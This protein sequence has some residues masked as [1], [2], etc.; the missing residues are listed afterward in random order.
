MK[1]LGK[2]SVLM[3]EPRLVTDMAERL[4]GRHEE[5][6]KKFGIFLSAPVGRVENVNE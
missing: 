2:F 3:S 4:A 6:E 5:A 1:M